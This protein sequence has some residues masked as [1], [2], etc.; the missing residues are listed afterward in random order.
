MGFVIENKGMDA[1][2]IIQ[3]V[4]RTLRSFNSIHALH[5]TAGRRLTDRIGM[6]THKIKPTSSSGA[7]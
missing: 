6:W 7:F 1:M 3:A 2:Q 4:L 5:R